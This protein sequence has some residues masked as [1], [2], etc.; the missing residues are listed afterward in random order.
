MKLGVLSALFAVPL[1]AC[2]GNDYGANFTGNW[3][4]KIATTLGTASEIVAVLQPVSA[5]DRNRFRLEDWISSTV[6]TADNADHAALE[7]A[8]WPTQKSGSCRYDLTVSSG[9]FIR[10]GDGARLAM[11]GTGTVVSG[12]GAEP[13]SA[14]SYSATSDLMHRE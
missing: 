5:I 2:G 11:V 10:Q 8:K 4:G 7:A 14:F 9:H 13:G 6:W 12:C 3:R 1:I